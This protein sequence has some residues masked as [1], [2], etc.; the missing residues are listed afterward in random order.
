[1]EL[2]RA[3]RAF[4][5][6]G[7]LL[8]L[9]LAYLYARRLLGLLP[10][11]AGF[12]LLAFDPFH[13]ALSRVLHLDGV[14]GSLALL[15]LL[16]YLVY[17]RHRRLG[18]LVFSAAAGSLAMLTKSPGLFTAAAVGLAAGLDAWSKLRSLPRPVSGQLRRLA[19]QAAWPW[20]A[21]LGAAALVFTVAWP[22]MWVQPLHTL[23]EVFGLARQFTESG[24]ESALFFNGKVVQDGNFGV[25]ST[26]FYPL[27][28]LWRTTPVT[29]AGLGLALALAW[30]RRP[31]FDQPQ[32][33][34]QALSLLL[35]ALVFAV[36]LSIPEKKFDRYLIPVYPPLDLLA[37][38]GLAGLAGAV[39]QSRLRLRLA[40]SGALLAACAA[41][42]ASA[43]S[44][45]PYYFTY[46]NPLL[47]GSRKVPEV[48]Q[49]GWG[50]GLDQAARYLNQKPGARDLQ[51]IT[52]YSTG[53]FS[54]YFNGTA[55]SFSYD[56]LAHQDEWERTRAADYALVYIGHRQRRLSGDILDWLDTLQPEHSIWID[57]LE[58]VRIYPIPKI[59]PSSDPPAA[60]ATHIS[61]SP[62]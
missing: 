15:S 25:A 23:G 47:G 48:M 40:F 1:L 26:Y 43:L 16:A 44:V 31:P 35:L 24:H 3:G 18:H 17:L 32:A 21:W 8:A 39:G 38:C 4:L 60:T 20:L 52:L 7:H 46:Y 34:R 55:R 30:M 27:T 36:G 56:S 57:G 5:L 22:A 53:C 29:L 41:Q 54:Y 19:W 9:C 45:A 28:Y 14:Y 13:I 58:M 42:A 50:E 12:T 62:R 6:A 11:L 49:V 10:A 33:R 37:G 51:V 2:L 59:I 61:Q